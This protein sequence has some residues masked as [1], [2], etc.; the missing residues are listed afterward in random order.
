MPHRM[1]IN[2]YL[3]IYIYIIYIIYI[4]IY[5]IYILYIYI[6]YIYILYI[7]IYILYIL[8]TL[9]ILYIYKSHFSMDILPSHC[10]RLSLFSRESESVA[11]ICGNFFKGNWIREEW[12]QSA[13]ISLY[14]PSRCTCIWHN[15]MPILLCPFRN[16]KKLELPILQL[17][18]QKAH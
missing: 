7:Y 4:Y 17:S 1:S 18:V 10:S 9:Y 3:Y 11:A 13:K 15:H 16:K 5:Y 14:H 6:L 8:Y 12:P 2:I